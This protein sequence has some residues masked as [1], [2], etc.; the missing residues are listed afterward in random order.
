MKFSTFVFLGLLIALTSGVSAQAIDHPELNWKVIETEHF[1]VHY[2]QGAGRTANQVAKIAEDI[3]PS[4][5]GLYDYRPD[6]KFDFVIKDTDDY[7][8]GAAYFFDTKIEIWAENLDYVLRGTHHW[9]LDV[10]T[11]EFTHMISLQTA[12]KF[13]RKVPAGWFQF[14]GYEDERRPD[15]VRGFPDVLISYPI[16]GVTIPA[17]FAEGTAQ[18]QTAD[19]R[20][21]YRDSHREMIL[22][23]RV[24]TGNLLDLNAMGTFGKNSIGN[25][26]AYNQGF[27]FVRFLAREYG[28]TVVARLMKQASSPITLSFKG[29]LEKVTGVE[30]DELH[31]RWHQELKSKYNERLVTIN[32]NLQ[33]GE[34][35]ENEGIGNMFPA[36]SPDGQSLAYLKTGGADYLSQNKLIIRNINTA[37]ETTVSSGVNASLAW[38]PGGD[39]LLYAK[40]TKTPDTGSFFSDL[41]VYAIADKKEHRLTKGMRARHPDWSNDG[42]RLSFVVGSDGLTHLFTMSMDD[43]SG[44]L[45]SKDWKTRYYHLQQHQYVEQPDPALSGNWREFYRR[46]SYRGG[47]LTQLT[48]FTDGRQ[49]FHPRWSPG[50]RYLYFDTALGYGRDIA[51]IP[52][53]GGDM[54]M[55]L[56]ER[57]DERYPVFDREGKKLWY[58]SD[59]TGIYN[60]YSYDLA[61]GETVSYSNVIGGAF[62]P[63]PAT[64][65]DLYYSHYVDQG[66]KIYRIS[67]ARTVSATK[68]VYIPGY[69]EEV[70]PELVLPD[71]VTSPLPAKNY[72]QRFT[73]VAFMPRLLIDYQ[74]IKPGLYVYSNELL[75]KMSVFGGF[76]VNKDRDYNL[77]GIFNFELFKRN[78]FVELYNQTANI[79]DTYT[80]VPLNETADFDVTFNL[81]QGEVGTEFGSKSTQFGGNGLSL[82][83]AYIFSRYGARIKQTSLNNLATGQL[84]GILSAVRYRYL[85]ASAFSTL[86]RLR[87]IERN[88]DTDINPVG[89]YVSLK[90]NYELNQFLKDFATDRVIGIENFTDYNFHRLEANVERYLRVPGTRRHSLTLRAQGGYTSTK[91]DSF[92]NF[93]AGGIVGLKGY[94]F[95]S[96]EGRHMVI[97][98]ATYRLPLWRNINKR[99][100]NLYFDKLYLSGFYQYG[101]ATSRS[102]FTSDDF[103]SDVGVQLRLD[104]YSWYLFPTRIFVEAAYPLQEHTNQ[105]VVYPREWKFYVGVLF[106]FDLRLERSRFWRGR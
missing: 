78:L 14:F 94:P 39:F 97:G 96:I 31:R 11:H 33:T 66:Y 75:D 18:F 24:V 57:F 7:A 32:A 92:F 102:S 62:M 15:V 105:D 22:R 83:A 9:L 80:S 19:R 50:D 42:K 58:A 74:T 71:T 60:L 77:F 100:L 65:G 17:W 61:S 25:E 98:T 47:E 3:Y 88:L 12:L 86:L 30:G 63:A 101:G 84:K 95:Y 53:G 93:F 40:I 37:E 21:D 64:N 29:V 44:T 1:R 90:Y 16:S 72:R 43:L 67:D 38:S 76:D 5:T 103:L 27:D 23:D 10:V 4:I 41:Y 54:T 36:V 34:A 49:I 48:R 87:N 104:T 91:V 81:F 8:N 46:C 79:E 55:I 45:A 69:A 2:H 26:S 13:S 6:F 82:R 70:I 99:F 85:Q 59:K 106:D 28:D 51:R 20:F 56:D 73:D 89:Y 68:Q 52:S 35:I